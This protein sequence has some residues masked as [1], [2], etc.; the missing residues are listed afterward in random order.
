M[1]ELELKYGCNPN[2]KP[3]KIFMEDGELPI[4]VLNGKPGYINFLDAFNG[5]QLVKELKKATGLPAATSFKHV[6]PAGAAVGLPLSEVESKI[7][8]V[9]DLGELSPLASAYARA[10][11]ADRMSSY[12]DFIALSDVCDVST[13]AV[14]KRE[15]SDGIIAPGYEPEALEMLKGKKKGSYA[16]IQ[17][18]PEYVPNPIERKEV[19]GITFEQGRNEL[20]IDDEF[21]S[22]V[23]TENKDITKQAKIDMAIAMITLKYTQSN[24]VCFVKNGQAIGVGA[25]QQS[26]IHC[27]RLAGQKADN[28]LLR[29]S[30]QVL[31]LPFRED[32]KRANRDNAIDLY[33]G[34]DYMDVLADGEWEKYFTEKPPVFKVEDKKAWLAQATDVVLGSDAFFPFDDNVERAFRS[35]VKYIAQPGGS[36][37][38]QDVIDACNKHGIAMC[39]TG[40]RLFHH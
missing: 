6:S 14:I 24:S 40:L 36:I 2:Q 13:A 32:M 30:P 23:V 34:E 11:G 33:I 27:T 38:D 15:F 20:N 19:F 39:F 8:W 12:G 4:E 35:G 29:Q 3:S 21:F 1:K 9:D 5:W 18:D 26:R 28:W 16:I 7:Y 37:R 17:I 25:G 31:S 10:R 22:N